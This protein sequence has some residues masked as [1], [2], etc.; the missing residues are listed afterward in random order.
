MN[1][2]STIFLSR[3]F[4]ERVLKL[5]R[6]EIVGIYPLWARNSLVSSP[7]R[8]LDVSDA[9][10][11]DLFRLHII[12]IE[13]PRILTNR[14]GRDLRHIP[15]FP[16]FFGKSRAR[17]QRA[18][19]LPLHCCVISPCAILTIAA[20]KEEEESNDSSLGRVW[21]M[22]CQPSEVAVW[23]C[24]WRGPCTATRILFM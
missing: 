6:G 14:C 22:T 23:T 11:K 10:S 17:C 8:F 2:F 12:G 16:P 15:Q 7:M 24:W 19:I 21:I 18:I 4:K 1:I 5:P 13:I 20:E 3:V 9:A